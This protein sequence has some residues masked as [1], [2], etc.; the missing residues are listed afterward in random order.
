MDQ[1]GRVSVVRGMETADFSS[2]EHATL[3]RWNRS[4][5]WR[6]VCVLPQEEDPDQSRDILK[7]SSH[8]QDVQYSHHASDS[9]ALELIVERKEYDE[10]HGLRPKYR[11]RYVGG[12]R[13]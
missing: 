13:A 1:L 3:H 4:G 8:V 9:W 12:E 2:D 6:L 11:S 10:F 5:P 7:H